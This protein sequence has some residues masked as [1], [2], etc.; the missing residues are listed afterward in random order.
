MVVFMIRHNVRMVERFIHQ[1]PHQRHQKATTSPAGHST[2]A[3]INPSLRAS[4]PAKKG[5]VIAKEFDELARKRK[6]QRT[7]VA[8]QVIRSSRAERTTHE[9][10]LGARVTKLT[11]PILV[12]NFVPRHDKELYGKVLQNSHGRTI[13]R[14][15]V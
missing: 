4:S 15:C 10:I 14:F 7:T 11:T 9:D 12:V 13:M 6:D 8:T 2:S 5:G 1:R 3:T